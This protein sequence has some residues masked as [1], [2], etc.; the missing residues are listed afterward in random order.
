MH[1]T[2]LYRSQLLHDDQ[3]ISKHFSVLS[4]DTG[5]IF[6]AIAKR[7]VTLLKLHV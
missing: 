2:S 4:K 5:N 6:A 1:E 7:K 3:H